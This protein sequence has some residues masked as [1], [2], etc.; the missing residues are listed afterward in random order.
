MPLRRTAAFL[1]Q[2]SAC[3]CS[4]RTGTVQ[5]DRILNAS[6]DNAR[7]EIESICTQIQN[8]EESAKLKSSLLLTVT[9]PPPKWKHDSAGF[10]W[11]QISSDQRLSLLSPW[12]VHDRLAVQR[13][14]TS[15]NLVSLALLSFLIISLHCLCDLSHPLNVITIFFPTSKNAT[16]AHRQDTHLSP[17]CKVHCFSIWPYIQ[18]PE[19][20]PRVNHRGA[21]PIGFRR[22]LDQSDTD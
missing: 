2:K 7:N 12:Y 20:H 4:T 13:A 14:Y 19:E 10:Q 6:L 17:I 5:Y 16:A 3:E 11:W 22:Q 21:Q 8:M 9:S 1:T 18:D 15:R